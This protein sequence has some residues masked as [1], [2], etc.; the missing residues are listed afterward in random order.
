MKIN[1]RALIEKHKGIAIEAKNI[2]FYRSWRSRESLALNTIAE[3]ESYAAI[4]LAAYKLYRYLMF[5][6]DAGIS[7]KLRELKFK[8]QVERKFIFIEEL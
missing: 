3:G 8:P 6:R 7:Q 4:T 2:A 1:D 5:F